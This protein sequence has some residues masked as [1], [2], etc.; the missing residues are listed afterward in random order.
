[1]TY[2]S[3]EVPVPPDTHEHP[4]DAPTG[5]KSASEVMVIVGWFPP[6]RLAAKT[7]EAPPATRSKARV[8][9]IMRELA[10]PSKIR[11]RPR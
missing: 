9:V 10:I 4:V 8:R 11:V 7:G 5:V 3:D 2:G 6:V 1:M